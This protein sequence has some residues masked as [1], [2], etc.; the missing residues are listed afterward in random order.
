M[1]D[2]INKVVAWIKSNVWLSVGIGFVAILLFFP[3]LL[4]F[5]RPVRRR[6]NKLTVIRR[7]KR[8]LPRSVGTRKQ[9]TKGGKAKKPWQI[10]GSLAAKRHMAQIRKMK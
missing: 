7:K 3:K 4:K 2:I 1:T 10:K 8:S 6:R 5:G 9:Y